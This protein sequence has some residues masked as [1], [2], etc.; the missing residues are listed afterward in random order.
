MCVEKRPLIPVLL[1]SCNIIVPWSLLKV[2]FSSS[3]FWIWGF[4]FR[5]DHRSQTY[6]EGKQELHPTYLVELLKLG[7]LPRIGWQD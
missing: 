6:A 5:M 1:S 4:L 7:D 2:S 3:Y